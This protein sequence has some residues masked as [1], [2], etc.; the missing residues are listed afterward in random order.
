[1]E[2]ILE[3]KKLTKKQFRIVLGVT[4]FYAF[5][6]LIHMIYFVVK[7][8]TIAGIFETMGFFTL[9]FFPPLALILLTY[10]MLTKIYPPEEKKNA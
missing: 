2:K 6:A 9:W 1:M 8:A 4:M 3:W 5:L 7:V 10:F